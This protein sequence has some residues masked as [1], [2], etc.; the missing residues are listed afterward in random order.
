M[1]NLKKSPH[2]MDVIINI[3]T[4]KSKMN[5]NYD[6]FSDFRNLERLTESQLYLLQERLIPEYNKTF[7]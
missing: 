4:M 6:K 7:A 5:P 3:Q 1:K 2:L